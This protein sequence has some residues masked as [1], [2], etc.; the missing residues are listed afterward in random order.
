MAGLHMPDAGGI[1]P[2]DRWTA[3]VMGWHAGAGGWRLAF[4]RGWVACGRG[5]LWFLYWTHLRPAIFMLSMLVNVLIRV[6]SIVRLM[7]DNVIQDLIMTSPDYVPLSPD[8]QEI[9]RKLREQIAELLVEADQRRC[10][11]SIRRA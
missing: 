3:T 5:L 7:A 10:R 1:R 9:V 11:C 8:E 2:I 4:A 6:R